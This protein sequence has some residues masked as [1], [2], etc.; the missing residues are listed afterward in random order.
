MRTAP[1]GPSKGMPESISAALA[2]LMA[3]TSWGFSWS[4]PI[5]VMTTWV[6]LRNP[7]AKLGRNGR[8]MSRQVRMAASVGRPSRRKNE[9]G[10]LPAAYIRSSTST[11]RGKKSIPSRTSLAALAVASTMV[12]PIRPT[13]APWDW[14]ARRPVSRLR[15]LSVPEMGLDTLVAP[16]MGTHSFR[17]RRGG[18]R[19]GPWS[20]FPVGDRP[21]TRE[22]LD[23]QL[24]GRPLGPT[25]VGPSD[26][27][28]AA[29]PGRPRP[30]LA[31]Q[32]ELG[33]QL[34]V[35]LDV[36]VPHVVEEPAAPPDELHQPPAGVVIAL[37]DLEVLG[38]MGDTLT[39]NGYLDLGRSGIGVV[40]AVGRD[41]RGF[42]WHTAVGSFASAC[43]GA[44]ATPAT[45]PERARSTRTRTMLA[46]RGR[47]QAD[48]R[49]GHG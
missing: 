49:P 40:E 19:S 34:P 42:V 9:P 46:A 6:S 41:R 30:A 32:A 21:V 26:A 44:A 16:C 47:E 33:D 23:W 2:A 43:G 35:A 14:W 17:A 25:R 24:A 18:R 20:Q 1:I 45:A 15:V 29:L 11:V 8:S 37:V 22:T 7:S 10:I 36:V 31:A 27:R 39:Q 48:S 12:S 3:S 38:E 28:R 5:T 4:A 13:T